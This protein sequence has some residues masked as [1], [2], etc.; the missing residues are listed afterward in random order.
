MKTMRNLRFK[1]LS[2][3]LVLS[4]A[5][6]LAIGKLLPSVEG[7]MTSSILSYAGLACVVSGVS[8]GVS[9]MIH[10]RREQ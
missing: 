3:V 8:L 7:T 6:T 10:E 9:L 5:T 1:L 2:G 4:G